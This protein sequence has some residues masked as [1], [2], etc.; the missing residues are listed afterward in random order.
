[1]FS[2]SKTITAGTVF[3]FQVL[4]IAG[5]AG[6]ARGADPVL[7]TWRLEPLH[8]KFRPGPAPRSEIRIYSSSATG[9]IVKVTTVDAKGKTETNEYPTNFDGKDYVQPGT[10]PGDTVSLTQNNDHHASAVLKHADKIMANVERVISDDG[11]TMTI[12]FKGTGANG[13]AV[14]NL[15]LYQKVQ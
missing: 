8:S 15:S 9:I 7:G 6:A 4:L 12:T 5:T 14:D 13:D 3:V 10:N 2:S 1:M 11:K